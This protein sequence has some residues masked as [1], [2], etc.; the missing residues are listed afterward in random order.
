[1]LHPCERTGVK[2][3]VNIKEVAMKAVFRLFVL[4]V[5]LLV[6]LAACGQPRVSTSSGQQGEPNAQVGAP[7]ASSH[8]GLIKDHV[9]FVDALRGQGLTVDIIGDVEQPFLRAKGTRLRISGG[10][11]K[12]P[13][14]VQSYNYDDTDL[15]TDGRAAVR[16][17]AEQLGANGMPKT[18]TVKWNAPP[19]WFQ[20]ER[21]IVLYLGDDSAALSLLTSLLGSQFAGQ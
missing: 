8:G 16:A 2:L 20:A 9:S 4:S 11:L 5:F 12:Q 21:V 10:S 15:G 6:G 7:L 3:L 1:M 17:D 18:A 13:I 19:H 14:D